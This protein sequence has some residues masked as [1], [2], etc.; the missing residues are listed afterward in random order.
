MGFLEHGII[1][2]QIILTYKYGTILYLVF[3]VIAWVCYLA[4]NI[5][6]VIVHYK[7]VALKDRTYMNW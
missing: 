6:F 2:S 3:I 1:L 4:T 5:A 7:Q